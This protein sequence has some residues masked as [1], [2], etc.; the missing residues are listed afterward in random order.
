MSVIGITNRKDLRVLTQL[1]RGWF[2]LELACLVIP[3]MCQGTNKIFGTVQDRS[4]ADLNKYD[5]V[6]TH[7]AR[8]FIGPFSR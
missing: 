2:C 5:T 6:V 8:I 7:S 4:E 1:K 3:F